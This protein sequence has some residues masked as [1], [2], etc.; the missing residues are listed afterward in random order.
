MIAS[1]V[2]GQ[3]SSRVLPTHF[4][5]SHFV[6]DFFNQW[7]TDEIIYGHEP[8]KYILLKA[9]YVGSAKHD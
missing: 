5:F 9:L 8:P 7:T 3:S 4:Q 2:L 1:L 6:L